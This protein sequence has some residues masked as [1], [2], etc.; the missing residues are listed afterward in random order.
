MIRKRLTV[1]LPTD[2]LEQL[3]NTAYWN[4]GTT[5]AS[6]VERGIRITVADVERR[7]GG[8]YPARAGEL[9]GGR[10]RKRATVRI[11]SGPHPHLL[12]PRRFVPV[13]VRQVQSSRYLL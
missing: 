9:K 8:P 6:L 11:H 4:P 3:R 2:L 12:A 7:H 10:P 13:E 5:L 1:N